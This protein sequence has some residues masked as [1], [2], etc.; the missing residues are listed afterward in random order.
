MQLIMRM[1][2][3]DATDIKHSQTIVVYGGVTAEI[4]NACGWKDKSTLRKGLKALCECG[5]IKKTEYRA[6]YQI[7]PK[8][9][10]KG[11]WKYNPKLKNGGVE[12]LVATFNFK[13][14]TVDTKIIWADDTEKTEI[15][16]MYR[17]GMNVKPEQETILK[18]ITI[19]ASQ[20][21]E[22]KLNIDGLTNQEANLFEAR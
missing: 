21:D 20:P 15:N 1:S 22:E 2:Y 4:C 5:A 13:D 10:A 18:Q 19:G 11:S 7:N 3:C 8:Y 16:E 6:T 9:A 17:A 14:K 12:D